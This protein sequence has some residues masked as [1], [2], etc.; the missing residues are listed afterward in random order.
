M[1]F[2]QPIQFDI[3]EDREMLD[4]VGQSRKPNPQNMKCHRGTEIDINLQQS[5]R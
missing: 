2:I 1:A 5:A 4:G 3:N